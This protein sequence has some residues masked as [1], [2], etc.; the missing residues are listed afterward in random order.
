MTFGFA[1]VYRDSSFIQIQSGR[2]NFCP[3]TGTFKLATCDKL[4]QD[5]KIRKIANTDG[6]VNCLRPIPGH[7]PEESFLL[8]P[9][10]AQLASFFAKPFIK[11]TLI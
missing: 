5:F 4:H 1:T 10:D 8:W 2:D 3:S 11:Y 6:S 9:A 7:N